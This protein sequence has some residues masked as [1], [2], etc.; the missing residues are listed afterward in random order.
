MSL[1]FDAI[2]EGLAA[3]YRNIT[4]PT[5]TV[6]PTTTPDIPPIRSA[7]SNIPNNLP[8][9]PIVLVYLREGT[10]TGPMGGYIKG[11]HDFDVQFLA[12]RADGDLARR[13]RV[14][15]AWLGP[16]L[17]ATYGNL[18]LDV[19]GVTKALP[20]DWV[21][22]VYEYGGTDYEGFVITVRVWTEH[23]VTVAA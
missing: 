8:A 11:E 4:T 15:K 12:S 3:R 19:T 10:V 5:L 1:D 13:V 6:A 18:N 21:F 14:L 22:D 20:T 7:T 17:D 16:L 9:L 23:V 2:A